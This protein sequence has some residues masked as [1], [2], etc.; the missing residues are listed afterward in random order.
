MHIGWVPDGTGRYRGQMTVLVK[1]NGVFGRA[2][3][4]AIKPFRYQLVYPAMLR[5][6]G[7]EWRERGGGAELRAGRTTVPQVPMPTHARTLSSLRPD[8]EDCFV[9]GVGHNRER[10]AEEWAR[11][12]LEGAPLE[13]RR[14]WRLLGLRLG[15]LR[16]ADRVLG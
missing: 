5:Q 2:Y 6:I 11:A 16:G 15:P 9:V 1:P 7:R 8:Y 3:M 10:T 4:A 14:G 13:V 12:V